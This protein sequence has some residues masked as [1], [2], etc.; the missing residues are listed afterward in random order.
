M[1]FLKTI[2]VVLIASMFTKCTKQVEEQN[3][4]T[5]LIS[6]KTGL[7]LDSILTPYV[8][9]FRENTDN[10]AGLAIAVINQDS[11]VYARTFGYSNIEKELEADFNT[12]F[13]IASVSKPFTAVAILKL[14]EQNKLKLDDP[15]VKYI[16]EFK[17][18]GN[19]YET[20]TVKHILTHTSGIPRHV[21]SN[22]WLNPIYGKYALEENLINAKDFELDFQP[23]S[24]YN[25]SNSAFDILGVVISRASGMQFEQYVTE[26]V[27]EPAGMNNTTYDK[28][29]NLPSHWAVP[30]S[31]A[32]ETQEWTPYPHTGKTTPS[33]GIQT[34][35]LDMCLW[36]QMH[37]NNGQVNDNHILSNEHF[38]QLVKPWQNTPWGDN[39]GLSWYLQSYLEHPNI[40]HQGN[41][42]G[43]EA[44]AHIYPKDSL[45]VIVLANRDFS[46][47]AR[48]ALATSEVLF[49]TKPKSYFISGR[50]QFGK[51]VRA[52]GLDSAKAL[53]ESLKMDTTD[54]YIASEDDLLTAGAVLENERK[55][56]QAQDILEYYTE[57]NSESTYAL[58][59]L[60][61]TRLN[62]N[63]TISAIQYYKK[64]LE[65]NPEYDKAKKALN[66]IYNTDN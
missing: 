33:S 61:N 27:F 58:R 41:D 48:L 42:T 34:T 51:T 19:G 28:P 35:L 20:I 44:Q 17:M 45:A 23:G 21:S 3:S 13:H 49:G 10:Q 60:G 53:F 7:L 11:I 8:E 39:I 30:Y 55:W 12:V 18:K 38:G 46:G 56:K 6:G 16:P 32:L 63:D 59:L 65:I 50:Y 37:L 26:N 2:L 14:I 9:T 43:F 64:A 57:F 15:I 62:L 5:K 4:T 66:K 31:Y 36:A 1:K 40:M 22:D 54:V 52:F 47:A 24:Q 29:K 25:Y